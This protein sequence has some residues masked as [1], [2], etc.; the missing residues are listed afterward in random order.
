[1]DWVQGS[2]FP[3]RELGEEIKID[4]KASMPKGHKDRAQKIKDLSLVVVVSQDCD[5]LRP[6]ETEPFYQFVIAQPENSPHESNLSIRSTRYLVL[7]INGS[8][9]KLIAF[10]PCFLSKSFV[11]KNA[12]QFPTAIRLQDNQIRI[13]KQ[14]M[15]LRFSRQAL[16]ENFEN[17]ISPLRNMIVARGNLPVEFYLHL[18][19]VDDAEY[20]KVVLIAVE[21]IYDPLEGKKITAGIEA[22]IF[23]LMDRIVAFCDR[24]E[25]L[26]FDHEWHDEEDNGGGVLLFRRE[27]TSL[28]VLDNYKRWNLDFLS[29]EEED[30]TPDPVAT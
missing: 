19:T 29:I 8:A 17:R 5:I 14:W 3:Y 15:A 7:D 26:E 21:S 20:F 28:S 12:R 10:K 6:S 23:D 9:Y 16:P 30:F 27:D 25:G 1:M 22:N 11:E 4:L 2:Y 24:A 18:N 13:L